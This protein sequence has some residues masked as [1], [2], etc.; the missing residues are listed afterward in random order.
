VGPFE[1]CKRLR[2]SCWLYG[3][4]TTGRTVE[5]QLSELRD[6]EV[7]V[8]RHLPPPAEDVPQFLQRIE[9][10][11]DPRRLL[12]TRRSIAIAAVHHRLLWLH[13]FYRGNGRV[14]RLVAYAMLLRFGVG[15]SIWSVAR[16][17]ARN[18]ER[19]KPH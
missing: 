11:Y 18:V 3:T 8:G 10:A 1:F 2:L 14:A 7:V 4:P 9:E 5:L 13:Q 16:G 12:P 19:Y 17:L 15:S 6:G